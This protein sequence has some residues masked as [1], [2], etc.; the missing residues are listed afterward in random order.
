MAVR[1]VALRLDG[2]LWNNGHGSPGVWKIQLA[3]RKPKV[4]FD[5]WETTRIQS[6][7]D[8]SVKKSNVT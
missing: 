6:I 3:D 7:C 4:R 2:D 1:R 8:K 5:V